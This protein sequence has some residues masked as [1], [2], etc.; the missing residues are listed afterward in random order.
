MQEF[1]AACVQIAI[2]P[3]DVGANI[4]KGIMWL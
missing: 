3:N 4:K 2:A 1:V